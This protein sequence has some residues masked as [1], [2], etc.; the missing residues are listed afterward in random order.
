MIPM[1]DLSQN[2]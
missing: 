2:K 1:R